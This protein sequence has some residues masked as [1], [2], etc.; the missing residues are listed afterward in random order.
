M[1]L[2]YV[3]ITVIFIAFLATFPVS[4]L[5]YRYQLA[6][7]PDWVSWAA[8]LPFFLGFAVAGWAQAVNRYF[9]PGVRLQNDRGQ[10]VIDNG[11][12]AIVRHPGYISGAVLTLS[13][14]LCLGS[15][16]GL[17]PAAVFV[18]GL[19]PRTLFEEHVLTGG[20][21]GYAAYKQQVKYR[22]LPGIW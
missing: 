3:F 20:L 16:W 14:P 17:L 15:W 19:I 8:Y 1:K 12:Y 7:T 2:D 5:D 21:A 11:P 4:A 9:E 22:W 10:T 13:I 6:Q 18:L